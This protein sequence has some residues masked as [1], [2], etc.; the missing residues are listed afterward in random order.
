MSIRLTRLA[1]EYRGMKQLKEESALIDFT[2]SG[3]PPDSY[4]LTFRCRGMTVGPDG[5]PRTADQHRISVSLPARYP[6]MGNPP[7]VRQESAI[8]HPNFEPPPRTGVCTDT[9]KWT[10]AESLPDLVLR[11]FNMVRYQLYNLGD[12]WNATAVSWVKS[13]K[14]K[15]PLDDRG[16]AKV[17]SGEASEPAIRIAKVEKPPED[18]FQIR[19]V[20]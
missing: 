16:W 14:A 1:S 12:P 4:L 11:L 17:P 5:A 3:D 19:V 9:W 15:F 6:Q 13:G 20:K 7:I 18:D 2:A 10:P 8:F